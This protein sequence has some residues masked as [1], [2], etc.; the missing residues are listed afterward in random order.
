MPP[1]PLV[2]DALCG[3]RPPAEALA[4]VQA[5]QVLGAM[6]EPPPAGGQHP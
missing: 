1:W 3:T 6:L 5:L 4:L 2:A